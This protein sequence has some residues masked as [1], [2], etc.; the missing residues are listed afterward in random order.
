M[1]GVGNDRTAVRYRSIRPDDT[2]MRARLRALA[3]ERRRFGYRRLGL[4][5]SREDVVLNHKKQ[6]RLYADE[7][8]R[9]QRRSG[10]KRTLGTRAPIASPDGPNQRWSLDLVSESLSDG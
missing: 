5:P 7:R 9:V 10:R 8:L 1:A 3:G 2:A 6:R 4:L